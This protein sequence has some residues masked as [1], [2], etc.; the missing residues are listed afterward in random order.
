MRV[1]RSERVWLK[2]N[3]QLSKSCHLSKNLFNEAN[4]IARQAYIGEKRWKRVN[5][6]QQELQS[7]LNYQSLPQPTASKIL[8]LVEKA[9]KSFFHALRD[10][11]T[12][13]V[14]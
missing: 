1:I 6:L 10:W 14:K 7:S 13:P 3:K 8:Q 9:W 11:K 2:P 12:Q 5:I 4:Y